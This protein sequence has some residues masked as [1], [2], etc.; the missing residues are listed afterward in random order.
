MAVDVESNMAQAAQLKRISRSSS[1]NF[2]EDED[3]ILDLRAL[4]DI[5]EIHRQK[6]NEERQNDI[7]RFDEY[8]SNIIIDET[9]EAIEVKII[10]DTDRYGSSIGHDILIEMD[11]LN[12]NRQLNDELNAIVIP[13]DHEI[14]QEK[15]FAKNVRQRG[16]MRG[17]PQFGA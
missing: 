6:R 7:E 10:E 3:H 13:I 15:M 1:N 11:Y 9:I 17:R 16:N 8:I 4:H 5:D 12:M 14:R 2:E